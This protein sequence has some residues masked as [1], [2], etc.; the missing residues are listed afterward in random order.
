MAFTSIQE[1]SVINLDKAKLWLRIDDDEVGS[2]LD[3]IIKLALNA[4]KE[5]ADLYCQDTFDDVPPGIELW[6]LQVLSLWWERKSP[7]IKHTQYQDLGET[8]WEFNYDDYYH[9]LKMYRKEW[10]FA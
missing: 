4:A 9:G 5:A 7:I 8:D 1:N 6:I 10:G 3:D 2:L